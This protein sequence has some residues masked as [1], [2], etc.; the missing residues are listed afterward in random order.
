[1]HH[2]LALP[3]TLGISRKARQ[4]PAIDYF[5]RSEATEYSLFL[6]LTYD[7]ELACV[8]SFLLNGEPNT[9][10]E[11]GA[12]NTFQNVIKHWYTRLFT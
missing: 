9:Q 5:Q 8:S 11:R 7:V 1:M 6:I 3:W 2:L 4:I 12:L 10:E